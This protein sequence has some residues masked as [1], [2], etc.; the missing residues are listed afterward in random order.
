MVGIFGNIIIMV[1]VGRLG[2]KTLSFISM[3]ACAVLNL[4]LC[5]YGFCV[6]PTDSLAW[7]P[8][9]CYVLLTFAW[10]AGIGQV[11]S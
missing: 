7:I 9:T 11:I 3:G 5:A 6:T 8:V 2:K 10:S 4:A 1:T